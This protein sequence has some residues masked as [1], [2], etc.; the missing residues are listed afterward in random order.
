MFKIND[1]VVNGSFGVCQVMD[2]VNEKNRA[3]EE[4]AYY[5]LRQAVYSKNNGI[6]IKMP[7]NNSQ[8]VMRGLISKPDA[9][10]MIASIPHQETRWIDDQA[11]RNEMFKSAIKSADILEIAKVCKCIYAEKI[12]SFAR[13]KR[14]ART[15]EEMMKTAEKNLFDELSLVLDI[16]PSE[17]LP[18]IQM[19]A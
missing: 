2:I 19:Q 9:L 4:T 17:V 5:V 7:V 11:Q 14:I 3:G 15:D 12:E 6:M 16:A 10:S 18:L 8:I 13:G 1:Y